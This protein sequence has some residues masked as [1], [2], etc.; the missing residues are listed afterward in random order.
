M[1][2]NLLVLFC[3]IALVIALPACKKALT[4]GPEAHTNPLDPESPDY[5]KPIEIVIDGV[6]DADYGPAVATSLDDA[7]SC[8][9]SPGLDLMNLYVVDSAD[10]WNFYVQLETVPAWTAVANDH[11]TMYLEWAP[12]GATAGLEELWSAG[13]QSSFNPIF[14]PEGVINWFPMMGTADFRT[15]NAGIPDWNAA[16]AIA[17]TAPSN[18]EMFFPGQSPL[19]GSFEFRLPKSAFGATPPG[20]L[21]VMVYTWYPSTDIYCWDSIPNQSWG[22]CGEY[23]N[24]LQ[25]Q[26]ATITALRN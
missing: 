19:A 2:R 1:K 18:S 3:I 21:K 23:I 22:F 14:D 6:L 17:F 10:Y 25:D 11:L 7:T 5:L 16:P 26:F 13:D 20:T 4:E 15:W 9:P 24:P 8:I 12:G